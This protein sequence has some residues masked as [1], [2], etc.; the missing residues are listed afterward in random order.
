MSEIARKSVNAIRILAADSVQKANSG[1][2]GL[3]LGSA[4][5]AYELYYIRYYICLV[6]D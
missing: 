4:A 3:P 6:M 1:H 2:P 5:M